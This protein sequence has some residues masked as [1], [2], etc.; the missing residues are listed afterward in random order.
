MVE[1]VTLTRVSA[2]DKK[3]DGTKLKNK[4][5]EFF[6]VGIQVEEKVDE[7]GNPI[8]INGFLKHRPTW[9]V[10]DK[11]QVEFTESEYKGEKQLQFRLP[12]KETLQDDKIKALEA[13]IAKLKGEEKSNEDV[14]DNL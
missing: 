10:G 4:F 13:E 14:I 12:K 7:G 2:T 8:W 6:R 5:G 11:I 3:A 9:N 1:N